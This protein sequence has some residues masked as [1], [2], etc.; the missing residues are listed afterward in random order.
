VTPELRTARLWL[1]PLEL[2]DAEQTQA[3]FPVWE[4]IRYMDAVVP[5]PYPSD[6][7]LT[8]YRDLVLPAVERGERWYWSI[9]LREEPDRLV[10]CVN[11]SQGG[12]ENRGI[13]VGLPWHRRGIGLEACMA[14]TAF[15]FGVLGFPILRVGKAAANEA[16]R[17]ISMREGMRL[18]GTEEREFVSG[19]LPAELWEITA[20]EWRATS[21]SGGRPRLDPRGDGGSRE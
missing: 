8:F 2:G 5:W 18:V 7:A 4:I 1:R 6:G 11:L 10:G 9:R 20:A 15:W 12:R 16:S 3:L 13:W 21:S 17:R 19:R 14:A